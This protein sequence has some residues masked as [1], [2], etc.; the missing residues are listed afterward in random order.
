MKQANVLQG[1]VTRWFKRVSIASVVGLFGTLVQAADAPKLYAIDVPA[2]QQIYTN[3]PSASGT[4]IYSWATNNLQSLGMSA[5]GVQGKV[6]AD[7]RGYCSPTEWSGYPTNQIGTLRRSFRLKSIQYGYVPVQSQPDYFLG[8]K[9]VPPV[10]EIDWIKTSQANTFLFGK[11]VF[12]STLQDAEEL[13]FADGGTFVFQWVM[14]DGTVKQQ[15]YLVSSVASKRPYRLFW[16]DFPYSAPPVSLK[17]KFVQFYGVTNGLV[18]LYV[19]SMQLQTNT[20]SDVSQLYYDTS[21][22][23][24]YAK[25]TLRGQF[26]MAYYD[27]GLYERLLDVVVIEVTAPTVKVEPG[28][29]GEQLAPSGEG[30]DPKGLE[31]VPTLAVENTDM[32]GDYLYLHRGQQTYSPKNGSVFSVRPTV[33]PATSTKEAYWQQWKA[34]VYWREVD[35]QNVSWPFQRTHYKC[36]WPVNP[37]TFVRGTSQGNLGAPVYIPDVYTAMRMPFQEPPGH[38]YAVAA[39]K[40]FSANG[41]GLSLLKLQGTD[42][43]GLD[44]IWFTVVKSVLNSDTTLFPSQQLIARVGDEV[45]FDTELGS[46]FANQHDASVSGYIYMPTSGTHYNPNT[47]YP[48]Q[49]T[50]AVDDIANKRPPSAIF[51][52]NT[53]TPNNATDNLEVWWYSSLKREKMPEALTF[54]GWKQSYAARWPELEQRPQLTLAS[55]LGSAGLSDGGWI[56]VTNGLDVTANRVTNTTT[57]VADPETDFFVYSQNASGAAGYNPNEEHAYAEAGDGG[58]KVWALRSDLNVPSETSESATLLQYVKDGHYAMQFFHVLV[59]NSF[60]PKLEGIAE[61][62]KILPGPHPIDAMIDPWCAENYWD[63]PVTAEEMIP[64]RD[65]KGVLWARRNGTFDIYM[66]YRMQ[67]SF[68]FPS[69]AT[70]PAAGTAIPWLTRLIDPTKNVLTGTPASWTW[71]VQWPKTTPVMKI[72]YTLTT[73]ALGLPEV[74]AA[75]SMAVLYPK[76]TDGTANDVAILYDPT[77]KR[78]ASLDDVAGVDK[79][80]LLGF[81]LTPKGNAMLIKGKVYFKELPATISRRFYYDPV[82][83]DSTALALIGE[84]DAPAGG[85]P[86]LHVNALNEAECKSLKA[87]V[88]HDNTNKRQWDDAIDTLPK[89]VTESPTAA[90]FNIRDDSASGKTELT[91]SYTP[92]DHYALTAVGATNYVVLIENDAKPEAGTGVKD[93]DVISMKVLRVTNALYVANTITRQDPNNLLAQTLD[94]LYTES[95]AGDPEKYTFEWQKA[96]P[97]NPGLYGD[98][99]AA[100]NGWTRFTLGQQGSTLADLVNTY[101]RVRY[102]PKDSSVLAWQ[103]LPVDAN[104]ETVGSETYKWSAWSQ[105]TLAEGWLQRVMNSV[106][107]FTQRMR[108]LYANEAETTVSMIQQA[109]GPYQ[110]DVALNQDNLTQ[111]GLIQLYQTLL[112][113]AESLSIAMGA[114]VVG[115]NNADVNSQLLMAVERLADLYM[116]LGNEAYTDAMNPTVGFGTVFTTPTSDRAIQLDYGSL[117][118]S[119]FCFDNQVPTLL[120]EELTLLRGRAL[121]QLPVNTQP[122]VY[123]R[124]LWNYTRGITAGEVAY[125]VNY[126]IFGEVD[127][128]LSPVQDDAVRA[129]TLFPQG[130]G[131]AWGHYLSAL[132]GY[133]RLL[134]NPYFS[135]GL[136]GMGEMIVNDTVVNV[137]YR[138]EERFAQAAAA[139]SKAS[140]DIMDRTARKTWQDYG[141][142]GGYE[143]TVPGRAFGYGEWGSRG[144]VNAFVNWAV[145]NSLLPENVSTNLQQEYADQG[146]RHINRATVSELIALATYQETIQKKMDQLD[147]GLNPLGFSDNAIPFDLSPE[148]VVEGKISHFEQILERAETALKNASVTLDKA[149]TIASRTR[150]MQDVQNDFQQSLDQQEAAYNEQ[151]I[152]LF[153]YP[154]SGDIGPSGTYPQ[155][156]MGPDLFHYMWMDYSQYGLPDLDL[157]ETY[158]DTKQ[159]KNNEWDVTLT[160]VRAAN[161]LILKPSSVSGKRYAMGEIQLAYIDFIKAMVAMKQSLAAVEG[162]DG[163]VNDVARDVAARISVAT[164]R[165][166]LQTGL[167]IAQQIKTW[168]DFASKNVLILA[169]LNVDLVEKLGDKITDALPKVMG[170]GLAVTIDPSSI[171]K[172]TTLP[173]DIT[174]YVAARAAKQVAETDLIGNEFAWDIA[175][176]VM[177]NY[178]RQADFAFEIEDLR[179][180]NAE[181]IGEYLGALDQFQVVWGDLLEAQERYNKLIA[182]GQR[183]LDEREMIRKQAVNTLS[184][185]RY[186]DMFF[187][188]TQNEGMGRYSTAF[189]LAQKYVWLA[190]KAY[191]YETGGQLALESNGSGKQFLNEIVGTRMIG[192]TDNGAPLLWGGDGDS[193]LSDILARMKANWLVLKPRL[194]INNPQQEV[195]WYSLRQEA[196]RIK[197]DTT[198][199]AAWRT[200]LSKYWVDDLNTHPVYKRFCQPLQAQDGLAYKEP[201][202]VIPFSTTIDFAKNFF[203]KDLAGG[204]SSFSSSHFATKIYAAGIYFAGYNTTIQS[205]VYP[206]LANQPYVYLIP[207]GTDHMRVPGMDD[208]VLSYNVVNQVIPVP[209][210]IGSGHLDAMWGDLYN[211]YTGGVDAQTKI[212]RHPLFRASTTPTEEAT[213][214]SKDLIGRSVWNSQWVLIV[215]AG[216]LGADRVKAL[217]TFIEGIDSNRDGLPDQDAVQD[218]KIGF[219]SYSHNGN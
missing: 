30:F 158:T 33:T 76:P 36:D 143:D 79:M 199:H 22:S 19:D 179:A 183:I 115:M 45:Q 132:T 12:V 67:D 3:L 118:S 69:L 73:A 4:L 219:R 113:K 218:I 149:Q 77:V 160:Y 166:A 111:V 48:Q 61:A 207:S 208:T 204:D 184:R 103:T 201:A 44:N 189:D 121:T 71:N 213:Y 94:V 57:V 88:K 129:A 127:P 195:T 187:R 157:Q 137:D 27:S 10:G 18:P 209:F 1:R 114:D 101:Y 161:G 32:Y 110:G 78:T 23:F 100:S 216:S 102:R 75:K 70:Q 91:V 130:H 58:I 193:G 31:A 197:P 217:R 136:P 25:G 37:T 95:F 120:D 24:L 131:D 64:F 99:Y 38:A 41:A 13:Y 83:E 190:A 164:I 29:V 49:R 153:G 87:L 138:E 55:Q 142:M 66:Y 109:G 97:S 6:S 125:S 192:E 174:H 40:T 194:G 145:A 35:S 147:A 56:M 196:F 2:L 202:L 173:L 52:V 96:S 106:T 152:K 203:G 119:L 167:Q 171:V 168:K 134:R 108:D 93:A 214:L 163:N 146:L 116:V 43:D 123:N 178:E 182:D 81:D 65:R 68:H 135:W 156:Y 212:R 47:Y 21:S 34:E 50:S 60:Y 84:L 141:R 11:R 42:E 92:V 7:G 39:D 185:A 200:E 215:P 186:N 80:T 51:V 86:M 26:L 46:A 98:Y 59:T 28:V 191:D 205:G 188:L 198:G 53:V 9:V 181:A 170:A 172:G 74:W 112:N 133:Y 162:A 165:N 8:E 14:K 85:I 104:T 124:L 154:I 177:D 180:Q 175:Q 5:G 155:G 16:T 126:N 139:M 148:D 150:Q 72:G 20:A 107:P 159:I 206:Q 89:K 90:T 15:A 54:P 62:G 117:S 128:D 105:P 151:L 210:P 63:E 169:D 17:G 82:A 144:A 140:V 211:N 122:P 176:L